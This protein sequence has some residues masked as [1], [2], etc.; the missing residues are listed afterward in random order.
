[1]LLFLHALSHN[2]IRHFIVSGSSFG[3]F[4]GAWLA[5][6]HFVSVM[7]LLTALPGFAQEMDAFLT[8]HGKAYVR[9]AKGKRRV[10]STRGRV[11]NH[12]MIHNQGDGYNFT[13]PPYP[14]AGLTPSVVWQRVAA[15]LPPWLLQ[16]FADA[17]TIEVRKPGEPAYGGIT[18]ASR[19]ESGVRGQWSDILKTLYL[20]NDAEDQTILHELG[21]AYSQLI[22]GETFS[23]ELVALEWGDN[24]KKA[25]KGNPNIYAAG[26]WC[27]SLYP[28]QV[29]NMS[30][31]VTEYE[32]NET[33][34]DS[35]MALAV[36]LAENFADCFAGF[37]N[38]GAPDE[39]TAPSFREPGRNF[40]KRLHRLCPKTFAFLASQLGGGA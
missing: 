7:T 29:A 18:F 19:D 34:T 25:M 37:Y 1:M 40:R 9:T 21:H 11:Y 5:R 33:A 28:V 8:W 32:D 10:R 14:S 13:P 12:V 39:A 35:R 15:Y 26:K 30:E 6:D 23:P 24:A 2:K 27:Y 4:V 16:R 38:L 3:L 20:V 17:I 22:L 36:A 31:D